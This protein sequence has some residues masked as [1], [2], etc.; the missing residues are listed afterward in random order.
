M[1]S[2]HLRTGLIAFATMACMGAVPALAD[3]EGM[4]LV[5]DGSLLRIHNCGG[6]VC[7]YI[8]SG[9]PSPADRN[10]A[11]QGQGNRTVVGM[12][13]LSQMRPAGPGKWTGRLTNPKDGNPYT[14]NLIEVGPDAIRIEGCLL[15][16]CG[17]EN[18]VR[19]RS[20]ASSARGEVS[21]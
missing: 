1:K 16:I 11:D 12:Q 3:V 14:G 2:C 6:A 18:L 13:V 19:A 21:R 8:V 7:G 10:N 5:K 20:S 9:A 4:W 15:G 17:G